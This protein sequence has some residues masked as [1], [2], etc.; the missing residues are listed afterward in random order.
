MPVESDESRQH[1][2]QMAQTLGEAFMSRF[3]DDDVLELGVNGTGAA[4]WADTRSDGMVQTE[5]SIPNPHVYE[6]LSRA[7]TYDNQLFNEDAPFVECSLPDPVFGGARLSGARPPTSDSPSFCLRKFEDFLIPLPKYVED[8]IMSQRQYDRIIQAI[9][10][11]ETIAVVGGTGSGKSTLLMTIVNEMGE[12]FPGER[13]VTIED[14]KEIF[15]ETTWNWHPFYTYGSD[16]GGTIQDLVEGALR[17]SPKRIIVGECRGEGILALFDALQSGHPGGAFT[18]HAN[19]V[20]KFFERAFDACCRDSDTDQHKNVIGRAV[21]IVIILEKA[22][23]IR[24]VKQMVKLHEYDQDGDEYRYDMI[25]R[26]P[27]EKRD[28]YIPPE[29]TRQREEAQ[30]T[31]A[32]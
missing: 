10:N 8:E 3:R 11:R 29:V 25:Y 23:G 2:E 30:S 31:T 6:F 20:G 4:V 21:D 28:R 27:S 22:C 26:D 32:V 13:V 16:Q 14:T 15:L 24:Y 19:S 9:T 7:A 12:R 1:A 17:W 18:F 5:V